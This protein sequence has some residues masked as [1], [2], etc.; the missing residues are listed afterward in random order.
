MYSPYFDQEEPEIKI[1]GMIAD[2]DKSE[3]YELD[4]A[5]VFKA[6]RKY[7]IVHVSGCSCWPD[8][9]DT[10]QY[11]LST[12]T[13]VEREIRDIGFGQELIEKCQNAKWK[14]VKR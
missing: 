7:L 9:G 10:Y 13:E 2:L 12:K 11:V 3:P 1:D 4:A 6:G 5:A 8:R 14:P